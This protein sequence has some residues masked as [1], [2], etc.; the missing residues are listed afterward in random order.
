MNKDPSDKRRRKCTYSKKVLYILSEGFIHILRRFCTNFK[1][2]RNYTYSKKVLYIFSISQKDLRRCEGSLKDLYT[3][4][5]CSDPSD[6]FVKLM[7]A[8]FVLVLPV[9]SSKLTF[10]FGF[11]NLSNHSVADNRLV[12]KN[13]YFVEQRD[14]H[15]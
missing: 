13:G 3:P 2:R 12:M 15:N 9:H 1:M 6:F 8:N 4:C 11:M 5:W 7:C 10:P 14:L